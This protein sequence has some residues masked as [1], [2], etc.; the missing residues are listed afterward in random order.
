MV[1]GPNPETGAIEKRGG[2]GVS[3]VSPAVPTPKRMEDTEDTDPL[4]PLDNLPLLR[5]DWL[6]VRQ[7]IRYRDDAADLVAG[8]RQRWIRAA[9]AE[10]V[11]FRQA[12]AGRRAANTWLLDQT[13]PAPPEASGFSD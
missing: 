11:E 1:P 7:R 13:A 3:P 6:F 10:P 8:Y 5:E 9:A 2:T 4:D 12:N